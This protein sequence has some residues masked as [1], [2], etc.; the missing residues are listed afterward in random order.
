[1]RSGE[2]LSRTRWERDK[3]NLMQEQ[4]SSPEQSCFCF[5]QPC[6]FIKWLVPLNFLW[7][8]PCLSSVFLLWRG[9]WK[10]CIQLFSSSSTDG[11]FPMYEIKAQDLLLVYHTTLKEVNHNPVLF[12]FG[13]G[14]RL[15]TGVHT[16][17]HPVVVSV[18]N[19][20][21]CWCVKPGCLRDVI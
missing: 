13:K 4:H 18:C 8:L 19:S 16:W 6:W 21:G 14:N 2:E 1:M 15:W 7:L 17:P 9:Y 20:S 12:H 10:F 5:F 3:R 11:C